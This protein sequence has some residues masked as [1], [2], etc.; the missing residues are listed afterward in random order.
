D[1]F[2]EGGIPK[3]AKKAIMFIGYE[4]ESERLGGKIRGT[5]DKITNASSNSKRYTAWLITKDGQKVSV[6]VS[7]NNPIRLTD[8]PKRTEWEAIHKIQVKK[9]IESGKIES[10]PDYP[11][12]TKPV[13]KELV[14]PAEKVAEKE[15]YDKINKNLIGKNVKIKASIGDFE[16]TGKVTD[17]IYSDAGKNVII[18]GEKVL[19]HKNFKFE[20]TEQPKVT[21][22]KTKVTKQPK[23]ETPTEAVKEIVEGKREST[24]GTKEFKKRMLAELDKAKKKAKSMPA[25]EAEPYLKRKLGYSDLDNLKDHYGQIT[26]EIPGD[27]KFTMLNTVQ[28]IEAVEK[29]VKRLP[30][31]TGKPKAPETVSGKKRT[32]LETE[33]LETKKKPEQ[34]PKPEVK[35]KE[36]WEVTLSEYLDTKNIS[37]STKEKILN[38]KF[39][40]SRYRTDPKTG[41]TVD[42]P[43]SIYE[44]HF[45]S[46]KNAIREGKPVPK[47]VLRDYPELSKPKVKEKPKVTE[48]KPEATQKKAGG[49]KEITEKEYITNKLNDYV[50]YWTKQVKE[51]KPNAKQRLKEVTKDR[52]NYLSGKLTKEQQKYI[53]RYKAEYAD[54]VRT[55]KIEIPEVKDKVA[56]ET[57]KGDLLLGE[58]KKIATE[59]NKAGI[60]FATVEAISGTMKRGRKFK[61]GNY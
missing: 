8:T 13:K 4:F 46:I 20:L 47:E 16:K 52:D 36:P 25:N 41:S 24:I 37:K 59:P 35:A 1:V 26:I 15:V 49:A 14:K 55:G 44:K 12:L 43:L 3:S 61:P 39:T 29:K 6:K 56:W 19:I 34:P 18:D 9:G 5:L 22:P 10:H 48:T 50:D 54:D 33:Y 57:E 51:N 40:G 27:G 11:E 45:D 60:W 30:S 21:K 38:S 31:G 32:E 7:P 23:A 28:A 2:L 42:V 17:V 58:V 53:D